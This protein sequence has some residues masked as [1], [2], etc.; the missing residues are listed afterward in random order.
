MILEPFCHIPF[1]ETSQ[2]PFGCIRPHLFWVE[3]TWKSLLL[4]RRKLRWR[5]ADTRNGR[6][7]VV[8][9]V[10][11]HIRSREYRNGHLLRPLLVF[12]QGLRLVARSILMRRRLLT[13]PCDQR[14]LERPNNRIQCWLGLLMALRGC[15]L[16]QWTH[17]SDGRPVC[18]FRISLFHGLILSS[19]ALLISCSP[20][21]TQRCFKPPVLASSRERLLQLVFDVF[22]VFL[23]SLQRIHLWSTAGRLRV[24][25]RRLLGGQ[26]SHE[27]RNIRLWFLGFVPHQRFDQRLHN[28]HH[29][30][31]VKI[32]ARICGAVQLVACHLCAWCACVKLC[33]ISRAPT[34]V[35]H[36]LHFELQLHILRIV[37]SVW[38]NGDTINVVLGKE[39]D[40][41]APK[42]LE[43]LNF[44]GLRVFDAHVKME[45]LTKSDSALSPDTT[46]PY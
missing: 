5:D 30:V 9:C 25:V 36:V 44:K 40:L 23:S 7:Q 29:V 46:S 26:P 3:G 38:L 35:R 27:I 13:L 12:P 32:L 41:A 39:F 43:Q 17:D 19:R 31:L 42:F 8:F 33:T 6:L 21:L 2:K 4:W 16:V 1:G 45:R 37:H 14:L 11:Q 24:G 34:E 20:H 22:D 28:V 18:A 10:L 15:R